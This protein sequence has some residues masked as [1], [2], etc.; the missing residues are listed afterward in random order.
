MGDVALEL[1]EGRF[2]RNASGGAD[3]I[4]RLF[5]VLN[6]DSL[7]R[8]LR[9]DFSDLYQSG[10]AYDSIRGRAHFDAGQIEFRE[11]L[12]V[13]SP[14]SRMQLMGR[15]DLVNET[16]DARLVATL[17]VASNLTFLTAL[18]GGLPA[19]AGVYL[20]SKLFERQ[21]DQA[22]SVSYRISGD[23]DDPKIKFDRLF[24]GNMRFNSNGQDD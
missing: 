19:A 13:R 23:W 10:L 20:V 4:L 16:L 11:P 2:S 8:R 12:L 9:L 5:A 17:P 21:V 15:I 22:T 7:A 14:S 1:T 6:F 24:E 18:V 3:G